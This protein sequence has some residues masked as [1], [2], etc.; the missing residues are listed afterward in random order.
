MNGNHRSIVWL[1]VLVAV[2]AV[3]VVGTIVGYWIIS[4]G[5]AARPEPTPVPTAT[6][7]PAPA[8]TDQPVEPTTIPSPT[9]EPPTP[10]P[11]P[12]PPTPS[13]TAEIGDA[14]TILVL[15]IGIFAGADEAESIY[16]VEI[17]AADETLRVSS[18]APSLTVDVQ[19]AEKALKRVYADVLHTSGGD[20]TLAAQAL[21]AVL[22]QE[23]GFTPDHYVTVQEDAL[24]DMIDTLGGIDIDVP[25]SV[26]DIAAGAQHFDGAT[27][28][29]YVG[30]L[31]QPGVSGELPRIE[32]QKQVIEAL[33][34]RLL[35]PAT[36]LKI[37]ALARRFISGDAMST[38]LST[39][40]ILELIALLKDI[41]L[42]DIAL[43][44][45]SKG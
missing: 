21:G 30:W 15:G 41:P 34:A 10:S 42:E 1:L 40:Q 29:R 27:A 24:V 37:P 25:V 11:T 31:A 9:P 2:F 7:V 20:E 26:G 22:A 44:V 4:G 3:L 12:K 14:T 32:R 45:V 28:W 18:F 19:D 17:D 43:T 39:G 13:P 16:V 23:F 33:R 35:S 6:A 36:V 5:R 38:D 8:A